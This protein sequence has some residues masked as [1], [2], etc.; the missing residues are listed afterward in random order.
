MDFHIA[1]ARPTPPNV[2]S[3]SVFRLRWHLQGSESPR[4]PG[5][6]LPARSRRPRNRGKAQQLGITP[7]FAGERMLGYVL[8][9]VPHEHWPAV[10]AALRAAFERFAELVLSAPDPHARATAHWSIA[11]TAAH[12]STTARLYRYLIPPGD[13]AAIVELI[14]DTT[15]DNLAAL[16]E[17]LLESYTERDPR[18]IVDRIRDDVEHMLDASAE[19]DPATPVRWL[20]G[21][22]V[23]LAGAL[24]HM[25]N[26]ILVH[27]RDIAGPLRRTWT[28]A[29]ADAAL[30]FD[31]FI[32]GLVRYDPGVF[33]DSDV[34]P[35]ERRVAVEFRSPHTVPVT[36][37]LHNGVVSA[38]DPGP[39]TDV[40][41]T[42]DPAT[43][44]LMLFHRIGKARAVL[45]GKVRIAGPRPW[46]LPGFLRVVRAP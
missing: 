30:V 27:S 25:L 33:L 18:V 19:L 42:F 28:I 9:P 22:K 24:G 35:R 32:A 36:M 4:A 23:P 26:E 5:Y 38:E 29:P 6:A 46:L 21:A 3:A 16:N 1:S 2:L 39:G 13:P 15:V 37:V 45:S 17:R 43:L 11:V 20:G 12:V 14:E 44:I 7:K 34:R 41:I 10:R 31:L 40:R 8:T